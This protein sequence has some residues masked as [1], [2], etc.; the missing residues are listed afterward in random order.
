[1]LARQ[2]KAQNHIAMLRDLGI[3]FPFK[4]KIDKSKGVIRGALLVTSIFL[5]VPIILA[6]PTIV[7][8]EKFAINYDI[9]SKLQF[10]S[11]II[12]TY[13]PLA[14]LYSH[15]YFP[16]IYLVDVV[17]GII[18]ALTFFLIMNRMFEKQSSL[19]CYICIIVFAGIKYTADST[20]YFLL[21]LAIYSIVKENSFQRRLLN[22]FVIGTLP[23][24]KGSFITGAAIGIACLFV[25]SIW[26]FSWIRITEIL[27]LPILGSISLWMLTGQ[28]IHDFWNFIIG[29]LQLIRGYSGSMQIDGPLLPLISYA[30]VALFLFINFIL[31]WKN[32]EA[33][34]KI[35][36]LS[37]LISSLFLLF[38]ASY[39][40]EDIHVEIAS[41]ALF[42]FMSFLLLEMKNTILC[43]IAVVLV[44]TNSIIVHQ[45]IKLIPQIRPF[46][47]SVQF[48]ANNARSLFKDLM[49]PREN[50]QDF[51][52]TLA[53][54][55]A[56]TN[57]N[58][59]HESSDIYSYDQ[60]FLIA[61]HAT[62]EPRPTMQ[63]YVG[64]TP[65]LQ[66]ANLQFLNG[67]NA[68]RSIYY[69]LQPID[70]RFPSLEDGLSLIAIKSLYKFDTNMQQFAL[71]HRS[72]R[73]GNLSFLKGVKKVGILNQWIFLPKQSEIIAQIEVK[74]SLLGALTGA[75]YKEP[76][77]NIRILDSSGR[78]FDYRFVPGMSESGF[79][80][81]P[82]VASTSD[83]VKYFQ[84]DKLD[85][86]V[87]FKIETSAKTE[88]FWERSLSYNFLKPVS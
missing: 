12:Y 39:V 75:L 86:V 11:K 58:L 79:L 33:V 49:R 35:V 32:G 61:A 71:L 14:P 25:Y 2:R 60:T 74:P 76:L 4:C 16:G 10:G 7:D 50:L 38:K 48:Y 8:G 20:F 83:V 68:P 63:S 53:S 1:M 6:Q 69:A 21:F 72:K 77:L 30:V 27:L 85:P 51:N 18:L 17:T 36:L 13:G 82:L 5:Y 42:L 47:S 56:E 46:A 40:R 24:I 84:N 66:G 9:A 54:I 34:E 23:L 43:A 45:S 64:Y 88:P 57:F 37:S 67:N 26:R 44:I 81:S 87:A 31:A 22:Y 3:K 55:N 28:K 59:N 62:Y 70:G 15:Q 52:R 78:Q 80:L 73:K 19:M 41:T 29:E 65:S